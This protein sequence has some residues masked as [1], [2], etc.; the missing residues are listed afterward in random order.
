ME[1]TPPVGP[2]PPIPDDLSIPQFF[3][4]SRHPLRPLNQLGNPWF[5]DEA[6]GRKIGFEEVRQVRPFL[7]AFA[8]MAPDRSARVLMVWLML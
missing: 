1:F 8:H 5:I 2:L 7:F 6:T 3:L 4:D